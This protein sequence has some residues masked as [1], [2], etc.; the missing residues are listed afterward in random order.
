[1]IIGLHGYSR[2]GKDAVA[3]ILTK[4][5]GFQQIILADRIRAILYDLNPIVCDAGF[6]DC[7]GLTEAV[8]NYG[9][10]AVKKLYPE[11]VEMMIRLGQS[12]RLHLNPDVWIRAA[13]LDDETFDPTVDIV[14]SDVRQPNEV[15]FVR[16]WGGEMWRITRPGTIPLGMD[17]LLKDVVFDVEIAND[18][19][20]DWLAV[21]VA[22]RMQ[23]NP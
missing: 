3:G 4:D 14:I 7:L 23:R 2:A 20:L 15:E 11:S 22:A 6:E 9:W 8:D 1:L 21:Q 19:S 16:Q 12:A 13:L 5:W 10:D 17:D 18:R